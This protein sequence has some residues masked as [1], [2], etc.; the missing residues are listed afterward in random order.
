MSGRRR[1]TNTAADRGDVVLVIRP[2]PAGSDTNGADPMVRLRA[3]LK[4]M[5]RAYRWRCVRIEVSGEASVNK[6][7]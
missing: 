7:A 4:S 6:R 1:S 2:E 5:L 3:L